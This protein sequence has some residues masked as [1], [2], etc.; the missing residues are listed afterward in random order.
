VEHENAVTVAQ[1]VSLAKRHNLSG[2]AI[3]ILKSLDP[4]EMDAID[5]LVTPLR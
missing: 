5:S 4:A 3:W 2:I 1:K